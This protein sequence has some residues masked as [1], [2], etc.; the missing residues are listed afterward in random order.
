MFICYTKC[1]VKIK[2]LKVPHSSGWILI[3]PDHSKIYTHAKT[4]PKIVEKAQKFPSD[5][6]IM[7]AAKSYHHHIM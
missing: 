2:P 5:S 3:S 7:A 4:F 6:I 1:M